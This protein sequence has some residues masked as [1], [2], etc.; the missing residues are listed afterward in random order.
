MKILETLM[1]LKLIEFRDENF[2]TSHWKSNY[3]IEEISG[4]PF[5]VFIKNN[6]GGVEKIMDITL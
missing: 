5:W 3:Y 4:I 2:K 6:N 1:L